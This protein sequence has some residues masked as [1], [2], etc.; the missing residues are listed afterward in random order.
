MALVYEKQQGEHLSNPRTSSPNKWS[1]CGTY[2]TH[3][4]NSSLE[5]WL[6]RL[7]RQP[8]ASSKN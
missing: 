5:F 3:K 4:E 7:D 8:L 6:G 2:T 1:S